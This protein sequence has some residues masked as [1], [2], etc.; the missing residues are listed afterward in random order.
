[1][2]MDHGL[3]ARRD[4]TYFGIPRPDLLDEDSILEDQR[5]LVSE[6]SRTDRKPLFGFLRGES[7]SENSDISAKNTDPTTLS[8]T[9]KFGGQ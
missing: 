4:P 9:N 3:Q 8:R 6:S 1:M 2:R 7:R 5:L